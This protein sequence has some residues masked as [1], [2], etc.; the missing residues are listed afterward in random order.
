[1]DNAFCIY[2]TCSLF[3]L[4]K[5]D[6]SSTLVY[7]TYTLY[8]LY[9][10]ILAFVHAIY[11]LSYAVWFTVPITFAHRFLKQLKNRMWYHPYHPL[12]LSTLPPPNPSLSLTSSTT[13]SPHPCIFSYYSHQPI[14]H[15][16]FSTK[17]F[18]LYS[19][20]HHTR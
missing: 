6:L 12:L 15:H 20:S 16:L 9:T 10:L 14:L 3:V 2:H 17:V 1:M 11:G 7:A 19:T 8:L 13:I 18:S 4:I 5:M